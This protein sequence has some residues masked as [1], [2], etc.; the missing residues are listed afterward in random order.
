M[1]QYKEA[2]PFPDDFWNY[3]INAITGYKIEKKEVNSKGVEKKYKQ[4]TQAI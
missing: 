2:D 4:I 3:N 1:K